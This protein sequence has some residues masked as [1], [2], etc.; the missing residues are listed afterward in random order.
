MRQGCEDGR[1]IESR[2]KTDSHNRVT[3]ASFLVVPNFISSPLIQDSYDDERDNTCR[4][5]V[6]SRQI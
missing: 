2:N 4:N 3:E 6:H 5:L 1:N